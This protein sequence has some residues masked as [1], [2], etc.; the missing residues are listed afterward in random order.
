[1]L[2]P[3]NA[4]GEVTDALNAFPPYRWITGANGRQLGTGASD[5]PATLGAWPANAADLGVI[6]GD[7]AINPALAAFLPRPND[8][9]VSVAATHLAGERDHV[10]L[11]HSHTWLAWRTDTVAQVR[12]FLRNGRFLPAV[13]SNAI[14]DS[15]AHSGP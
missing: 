13:T 5:L 15:T 1:M 8:G 3:P 10:V 4:G 6:A 12:A 11:H 2:A 14:A 9:K 7:R